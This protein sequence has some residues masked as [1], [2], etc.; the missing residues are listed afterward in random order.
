LFEGW[1]NGSSYRITVSDPTTTHQE[2]N[3]MISKRLAGGDITINS[4]NISTIKCVLPS[5]DEAGK[6]VTYEYSLQ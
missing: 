1:S 3:I 4:D 2:L 6:S 5:G